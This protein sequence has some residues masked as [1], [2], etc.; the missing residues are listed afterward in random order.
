MPDGCDE[1]IACIPWHI[2]PIYILLS[3]LITAIITTATHQSEEMPPG[4]RCGRSMLLQES[5]LV[6]LSG[7]HCFL[8][9]R[10]SKTE[11]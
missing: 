11:V 8:M 2:I 3:G 5:E 10:A 4:D 1:V 6:P 7:F 9:P